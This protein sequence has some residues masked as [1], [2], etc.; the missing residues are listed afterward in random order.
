MP[1]LHQP[2]AFRHEMTARITDP[3]AGEPEPD[4]HNRLL[5]LFNV[6]VR[7]RC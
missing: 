2:L 6:P 1:A 5:F 4:E 3:S 7:T